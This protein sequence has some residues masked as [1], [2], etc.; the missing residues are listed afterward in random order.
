MAHHNRT[1]HREGDVQS[2]RREL[3][4]LTPLVPANR[5][6]GDHSSM[7]VYIRRFE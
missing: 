7:I 6:P 3:L 1:S 5:S 2:T 4:I